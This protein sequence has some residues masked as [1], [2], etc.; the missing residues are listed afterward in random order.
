[1][2]QPS[3]I[4]GE[5]VTDLELKE[6]KILFKNF[7][8]IISSSLKDIFY[9]FAPDILGEYIFNIKINSNIRN[10]ATSDPGIEIATRFKITVKEEPPNFYGY[11]E[12]L[13]TRVQI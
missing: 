1:M 12:L 7:W 8:K 5:T 11:F 9:N 3:K 6:E 4:K 10:N 13:V 2:L